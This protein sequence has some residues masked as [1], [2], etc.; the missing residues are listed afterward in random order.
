MSGEGLGR[1][2][3]P[4]LTRRGKVD[5]GMNVTGEQSEGRWIEV[6]RRSPVHCE[7]LGATMG[8]DRKYGGA[9][10]VLVV[11]VAGYIEG[12]EERPNIP[13]M[14][15]SGLGPSGDIVGLGGRWQGGRCRERLSPNAVNT[16]KVGNRSELE[17]GIFI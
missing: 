4:G 1:G 11:G 7:P 8:C 16:A 14:H 10:T 12:L 2:I 17:E 6:A 15:L 5:L 13:Y 3:K 9:C